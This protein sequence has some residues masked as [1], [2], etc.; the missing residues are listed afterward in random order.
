MDVVGPQGSLVDG[1]LQV[2]QVCGGGSGSGSLSGMFRQTK[3]ASFIMEV[4]SHLL[5][6]VFLDFLI[7]HPRRPPQDQRL[8][9]EL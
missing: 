4:K 7:K 3:H 5:C 8:D 2:Q 9:L 6:A 1:E